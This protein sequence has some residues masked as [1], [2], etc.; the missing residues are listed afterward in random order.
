MN[1]IYKMEIEIGIITAAELKTYIGMGIITETDYEWIVG[2]NNENVQ[3][4]AP[5]SQA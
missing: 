5:Q 2:D 4:V 1:E 3:T